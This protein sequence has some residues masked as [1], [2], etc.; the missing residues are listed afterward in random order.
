MFLRRSPS[1]NVPYDAVLKGFSLKTVL[2][3]GAPWRNVTLVNLA[4]I[5]TSEPDSNV[6]RTFVEKVKKH[7]AMASGHLTSRYI[8]L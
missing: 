7:N 5:N 2:L 3:R 8:L 4:H 6:S 1:K